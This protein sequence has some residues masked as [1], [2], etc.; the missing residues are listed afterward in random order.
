[1][2]DT[3]LVA[4]NCVQTTLERCGQEYGQD[5]KYCATVG[6]LEA[7]LSSILWMVY[8][9]HPETYKEAVAYLEYHN[10]TPK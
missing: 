9:K 6:A 5:Y 10:K 2:T 1:M 7:H 3:Y 4:H 8:Y